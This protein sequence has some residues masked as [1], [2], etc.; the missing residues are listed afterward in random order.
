MGPIRLLGRYFRA[1]VHAQAQYPG[2]LAMLSLGAFVANFV[3]V[4]AIAALFARFGQVKGWTFGEVAMFYGVVSVAFA[5][6][7]FLS[8]GFDVL[9]TEFIRTGAFDRLLLRPRSLTVQLVGHDPRLSR[10]GRLAQ[11]LAALALATVALKFRWDASAVALA[12]WTVLGGVALFSGIFMLQATL[13]FWTVESLEVANLLTYGGVQAAQFPLSLYAE[14]FRGVLIFIVPLGCVAY[15][16]VVG[17]LGRHDPL[18]APD[19]F[20]PLAPAA[21]FAFLAAALAVWRVGVRHYTSTGS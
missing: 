14:W 21:G 3:D 6:A 16:P 12:A 9:G 20:L 8:R 1:S 15:F 4:I 13:A 11:G 10:V 19:W 5:F 2:S 18:G 17:L 7:D